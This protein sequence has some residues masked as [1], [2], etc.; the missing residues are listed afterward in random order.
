MYTILTATYNRAHTLDR[1]F[2]SL[3]NQTFK[4][5]DWLIIDDG[6]QDETRKLIDNYRVNSDFPIYYIYKENGGKYTA[7]IESRKHLTKPFVV[8]LDSDDE[9]LPKA[10]EIFKKHFDSTSNIDEVRGRCVDDKMNLLEKFRF[11]ENKDYLDSTW[12]EMVLRNKNDEELLSCFKLDYYL[13]SVE[14]PDNLIFKDK[15]KCFSEGYFWAKIKCSKIRYIKE[16]LR[17]YHHDS[18]NSIMNNT[19]FITGLYDD[20]VAFKYF[21]DDNYRYFFWRPKYFL[22]QYIKLSICSI[23]VGHGFTKSHFLY[24]K[25]V[26]RLISLALSPLTLTVYYKMKYLDEKFWR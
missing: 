11:P 22:A 4:D 21:L 12:H 1:L 25:G 3:Q 6:S 9:L 14:L 26:N 16:P 15:F 18:G 7:L 24:S 2:N 20:I 8:V 17:V 5:F 13:K 23:L 10:L 19:N